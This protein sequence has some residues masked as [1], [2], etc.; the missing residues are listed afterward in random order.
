MK[1]EIRGD[2]PQQQFIQ[3]KSEFET[4]GPE[5]ILQFPRWRP[6]RYE[7]GNFA[8]NVRSLK[9]FSKEGQALDFEKIDTHVW[10][11]SG[12]NSTQISVRYSYYAAELNAGST[13]LNDE[14][15]YINPVNC[16]IFPQGC[17]DQ[18]CKLQVFAPSSFDYAGTL[19]QQ[20]G[21][22]V[23]QDYHELVDSP[24]LFAKHVDSRSYQ[25]QGIDFQVSFIE[26]VQVPWDRVLQDFEKFTREQIADFGQFP[27]PRYH[28]I[29]II[30]PYSHYHGVEHSASTIIV[31]GPDHA[32]FNKL[33]DEL[34]GVSS[35]ELYH[36][37]NVKSIRSADMWP[38]DYSKENLSA[39]GYLC[40]GV[41]TYLGDYYL[42]KCGIWSPKRYWKELEILIQ[43]HL[44]NFG[45]FNSSLAESSFDTWLDGYVQGAPGRKVSIYNEGA[46]FALVTDVFIR[47]RTQGKKSI[48]DVMEQLYSR[49]YKKNKGIMD[50]DYINMVIEISEDEA[51]RKL[52]D[53]VVHHRISYDSFVL[54]ALEALGLTFTLNE[55]KDLAAARLGI[56]TI[57]DQQMIRVQAIY[58]GSSADLGGMMLGDVLVSVNNRLIQQDLGALL[59]ELQDE[60]LVFQVNRMSRLITL[61]MPNNLGTCYK[62]VVVEQ[63]EKPTNLAQR[64]SQYWT[65]EKKIAKH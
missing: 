40:E 10:R 1:Y 18:S 64:V 52:F 7:L 12:I 8:K 37:W 22:I 49:F 34:L 39:M 2:F 15:L 13:F 60:D 16:L 14:M 45:R 25:V 9:V 46:L 19:A 57:L 50:E 23:A 20:N 35:H 5:L 55:N 6:G 51:Y 58:P 36:A 24:F 38:Y 33:Y 11:V 32:V 41:T 53:S 21:L 43:R 29:N 17:E 42:M 4:Q 63:L 31:L 44:D 27:E 3:I 26:T 54:E 48:A 30:L 56:K 59:H 61:S 65:G 28:F 47:Q 62:E